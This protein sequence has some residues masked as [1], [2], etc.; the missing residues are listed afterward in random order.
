MNKRKTLIIS[1]M[2]IATTVLVNYTVLGAENWDL[3]ISPSS[4]TVSNNSYVSI[5]IIANWSAEDPVSGW[6]IEQLN[7]SNA[8]LGLNS[9]TEGTW[10]S[11]VGST[12]FMDGTINNGTG[13]LTDVVC[14]TIAGEN[15]TTNGTLCTLN[16]TAE[17]VGTANINFTIELSFDGNTVTSNLNTGTITIQESESPEIT[18]NS[19]ASGTT[20]DFFLFNVTVTD[21]SDSADLLTVKVNWVHGGNNGN[22]TMN[23]VGG[24]YFTYQ[25]TLATDS[26]SNLAYHIWANDTV[27]NANYTSELTAT[28]TDNDA[29]WVTGDNPPSP[30]TGE[31]STY[32]L[33][34]V[35]DNIDVTNVHINFRLNRSG[36]QA[37]DGYQGCSEDGDND[38]SKSYGWFT[39]SVTGIQYYYRVQDGTNTIYY[40]DGD[41]NT[42]VEGTAQ[43]SAYE[44]LV[45]DNDNPNATSFTINEVFDSDGKEFDVDDINVTCDLEDNINLNIVKFNGSTN[46]TISD[47]VAGTYYKDTNYS[48]G[49]YNMF[50][51][52]NDTT[53]N[54]NVT[55]SSLLIIYHYWDVSQDNETDINDIT[56]VTGQYGGT[57]ATRWIKQDIDS[58]GV[59]DGEIDINDI[60]KV[61]GHY[62]EEY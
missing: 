36:W 14:Y 32:E 58:N 9:V 21:N 38:W 1:L 15:T 52:V 2:L 4:Q 37:W 25:A 56:S 40:Y 24:N 62:G 50:W 10:L 57:G 17:D 49:L 44:I 28:V 60:T 13:T 18:D 51:W 8:Y 61:T 23:H 5:D 31:N 33:T 53:G 3:S 19:P 34:D 27:P 59:G 48:T 6:E 29:P 42:S 26:V 45:S 43:A 7:F 30:T 12:G 11:N 39:E 55:S 20:G 35:I 41:V 47:N 16:F 54:A 22:N 46:E